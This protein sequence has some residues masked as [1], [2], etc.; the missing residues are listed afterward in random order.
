MLS[1]WIPHTQRQMPPLTLRQQGTNCT[2]I[3]T[4]HSN[5]GLKCLF[6]RVSC[7][8]LKLIHFWISLSRLLGTHT[9]VHNMN[10]C[11]ENRQKVLVLNQVGTEVSII[12]GYILVWERIPPKHLK[13]SWNHVSLKNCHLSIN[14]KKS[15]CFLDFESD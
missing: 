2:E 11:Q 3:S 4:L 8:I 10:L 15:K 12:P 5:S 14:R 7:F 13:I 1:R 9:A 6:F